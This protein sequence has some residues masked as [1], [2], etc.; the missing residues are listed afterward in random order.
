MTTIEIEIAEH[1]AIQTRML[2]IGRLLMESKKSIQKEIRE[3]RKTPEFKAAVEELK[4]R[5]EA[6]KQI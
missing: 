6:R 2:S 1:K 3:D 4:K 5:N